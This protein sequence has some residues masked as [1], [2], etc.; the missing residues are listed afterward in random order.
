MVSDNLGKGMNCENL[1]SSLEGEF[2]IL[3]SVLFCQLGVVKS[4]KKI[5]T[6]I[7]CI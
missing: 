6:T 4:L 3:F 1:L 2:V 5:I 7:K